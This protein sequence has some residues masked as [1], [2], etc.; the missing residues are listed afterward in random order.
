MPKACADKVYKHPANDRL[1]ALLPARVRARVL[2]CGCGAGA[3]ARALKARGWSVVGITI[4]RQEQQLAEMYCE[5]VHVGDLNDGV[6]PVAGDGYD[7]VLMSHV[8]EHLTRPDRLLADAQRVLATGGVVAVAL[9]NALHFQTRLKFMLGKF[10]YTAD[11]SLD[12]THV[13]FYTVKTAQQLLE[14]NGFEVVQSAT[15]G[16]LPL[17]KFRSVLPEAMTRWLDDAASR[18]LPG[19]FGFQFLYI[20]R[21]RV[22]Q[23][24]T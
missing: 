17:W 6:P 4:S 18:Y 3:N 15:H 21:P 24:H 10:D 12:E 1:L 22:S 13:R 20:M 23:S 5:S 14:A 9:P 7:I 2:D 11:G 8:L 16:G 19:L